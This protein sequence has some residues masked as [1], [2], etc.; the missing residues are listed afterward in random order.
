MNSF[1]EVCCIQKPGGMPISLG[2]LLRCSKIASVRARRLNTMLVE[3]LKKDAAEAKLRVLR[4]A[5]RRYDNP[6]EALPAIMAAED[7]LMNA[8]GSGGLGAAAAVGVDIDPEE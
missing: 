3:A 6:I 8:A 2:T 7:N 4:G 5:V 1:D